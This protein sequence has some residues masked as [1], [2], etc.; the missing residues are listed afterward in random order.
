MVCNYGNLF[1]LVTGCFWLLVLTVLANLRDELHTVNM[2]N[3]SPFTF[4]DRFHAKLILWYISSRLTTLDSGT[5][6]QSNKKTF[7]ITSTIISEHSSSGE[8][9]MKKIKLKV[10]ERFAFFAKILTFCSNKK[11][12][13]AEEP[14]II[15][16]AN[17]H[18][19]EI[20]VM[21]VPR[22]ERRKA[23]IVFRNGS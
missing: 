20:E 15:P 6:F 7:N 4:N 1:L 14:A 17:N 3:I 10:T 16:E 11:S 19:K 8:N 2:L 18:D 12:V 5:L 21:P 13:D 9:P 23:V 22:R